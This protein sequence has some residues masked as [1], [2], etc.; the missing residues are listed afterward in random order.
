MLLMPKG[1]YFRLLNRLF[2][3]KPLANKNKFAGTVLANKN[4]FAKIV[5]GTAKPTNIPESKFLCLKKIYT[6][7]F[8]SIK[9]TNN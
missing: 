8:N 6:N 9:F 1:A 2:A 3:R 5:H 4:T 7:I